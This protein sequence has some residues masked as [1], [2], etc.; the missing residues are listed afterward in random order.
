MT[1]TSSHRQLTHVPA[2]PHLWGV[3]NSIPRGQILHIVVYGSPQLQ[4]LRK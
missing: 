1:A 4:N 2:V 3:W